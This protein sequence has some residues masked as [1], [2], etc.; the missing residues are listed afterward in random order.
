MA[1]DKLYT[2]VPFDVR[3]SMS[4]RDAAIAAG[5]T[6]RTMRNW[7]I[8]HGIGRR[9]GNTWLVSRV[10]LQMFLDGDADSLVS[11]R[12]HGVRASYPPVAEYFHRVDLDDLLTLPAYQL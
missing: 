9:V 2:L 12:D 1:N 3:E 5:K 8:V 4:L 10:A 11:Y 7:C 6:G